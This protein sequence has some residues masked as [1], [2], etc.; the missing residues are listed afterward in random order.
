MALPAL[1]FLSLVQPGLVLSDEVEKMLNPAYIVRLL[2]ESQV[3]LSS[4]WE[5]IPSIP[6]H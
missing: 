1:L 2:K 3:N 6:V 5:V 4:I